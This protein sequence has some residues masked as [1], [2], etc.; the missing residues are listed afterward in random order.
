VLVLGSRN[1]LIILAMTAIM[2]R[3]VIVSPTT[4]LLNVRKD[5]ARLER[6]RDTNYL[7]T[8]RIH[9]CSPCELDGDELTATAERYLWC[10]RDYRGDICW[11][12]CRE[13]RARAGQEVQ[14]FTVK[15]LGGEG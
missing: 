5:S 10:R 14:T 8:E 15:C 1:V 7:L 13:A 2:S 9:S 11:V 12:R 6:H 3:S 4:M